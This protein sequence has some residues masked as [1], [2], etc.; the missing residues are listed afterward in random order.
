MD[1][2]EEEV[3]GASRGIQL[4]V[5]GAA[6]VSAETGVFTSMRRGEVVANPEKRVAIGFARDKVVADVLQ[7]TAG[8]EVLGETERRVLVLGHRPEGRWG[9]GESMTRL[10]CTS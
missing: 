1:E 8:P 2:V 6:G 7:F 4:V 5:P 3:A 10:I 9:R